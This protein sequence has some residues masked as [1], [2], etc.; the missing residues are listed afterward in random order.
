MLFSYE[1]IKL[2]ITQSKIVLTVH[3]VLCYLPRKT[4]DHP[5]SNKVNGAQGKMPFSQERV[6]LKISLSKLQL[7]VHMV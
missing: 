2:K 5:V 7:T 4:E 3:R 6:R 1:R